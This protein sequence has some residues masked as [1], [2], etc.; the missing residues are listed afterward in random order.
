MRLIG[1]VIMSAASVSHA[2]GCICDIRPPT[3]YEYWRTDVV[4]IGTVQKVYRDDKPPLELEK[5]EIAVTENFRGME[6]P[7][8]TTFNYGHSCAHTFNKGDRF[9]F[10]GSAATEDAGE[11]GTSLCMRTNRYSDTLDDL[12]FLRAVRDRRPVYWAWGTISKVG[13]DQPLQGIRAEV[14]GQ[15]RRIAAT[16]DEKGDIKLEVPKP[17]KYRIRTYLPKG[18]TDINFMI[19]SDQA[20]WDM[21]RKQIVGGRFHGNHPYVDFQVVVEASR[22]GW[23][24]VSI[25]D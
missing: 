18:R 11:F 20:L 3:C 6:R 25:P 17:G 23:F 22:C 2:L 14:L 5:V 16:S 4:F 12:E 24:D 8:A 10:Y 1:I 19:R 15:P 9:L 7:L 13:Y 21:Q